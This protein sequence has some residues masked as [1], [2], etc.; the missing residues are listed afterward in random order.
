PSSR[1]GSSTQLLSGWSALGLAAAGHN[2]RDVKRRGGRSLADYLVRSARGLR[3]VGELERTILVL[4][5]AGLSPRRF[6]GRDLV[7]ELRR[8]LR[9]DG[10]VAGYVSYTAFGLLAL[11]ASGQPLPQSSLAWLEAAQ[12]EDGG[13]GVAPSATS[14]TDMTGAVLQ[15]LAAAGRPR[16]DVADRAGAY[17]LGAQRRDGGFPQ[18]RG[19]SSNAQSTAYAVQGL[20]ATRAAPGQV[21]LALRYLTRLQARDGSVRYSRTSSQ[22][23]VWVTAQA[24][25]A[26]RGK[27]LPLSVVPRKRRARPAVVAVAPPAPARR[28]RERSAKRSAA[29]AGEKRKPA[30]KAKKRTSASQQ[31]ARRQE[32][33]AADPRPA[34]AEAPA[35]AEGPAGLAIAAGVGGAL[36][37][38]LVLRRQLRGRRRPATG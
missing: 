5:A 9:S 13:F 28:A 19:R 10:S 3:D 4:R 30:E 23:P 18:M 15:A 11:R 32:P 12:N 22:T 25:M 20:L 34:R 17:L 33:A 7:A 35:E 2:P 38:L 16:G 14:D 6:A 31:L 26:L 37:L 1:G 8:R 36:I 29:A 27:P 24:L 21:R